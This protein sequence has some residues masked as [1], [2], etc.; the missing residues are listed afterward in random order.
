M[1]EGSTSTLFEFLIDSAR[2]VSAFKTDNVFP[3]SKNSTGSS[4]KK[5]SERS[6][7]GSISIARV[8]PFLDRASAR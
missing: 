7:C 4:G 2:V 3:E 1:I 8:E 6:A 5:K